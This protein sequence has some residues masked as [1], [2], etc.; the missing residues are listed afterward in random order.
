ML[1]L[2]PRP[3]GRGDVASGRPFLVGADRVAPLAR[4][5]GAGR[6]GLTRRPGPIPGRG[7]SQHA[8]D[9][10]ESQTAGAHR[11]LWAGGQP[12][13]APSPQTLLLARI[14]GLGGSSHPLGTPGLDL[15]E[16]E[17]RSPSCDEVDL[18]PIGAYVACDDAISLSFQVARR[19]G[20]PIPAKLR[21]ACA[22]PHGRASDGCW[23]VR[24]NGRNGRNRARGRARL[25]ARL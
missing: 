14:D 10:V 15:D 18:D 5:A 11:L 9:D 25:R 22:R 3:I 7:S 17:Q 12:R 6:S 8:G 4:L 2:P 21:S 19:P 20:F 16:D 13:Q 23:S 1:D 24:M